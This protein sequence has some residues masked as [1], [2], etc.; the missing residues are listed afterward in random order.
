MTTNNQEQNLKDD[1]S[2]HTSKFQMR[3]YQASRLNISARLD[4]LNILDDISIKMDNGLNSYALKLNRDEAICLQ[5]T[6]ENYLKE[7]K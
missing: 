4:I 7:T 6:L 5:K 1:C 3:S 2:W